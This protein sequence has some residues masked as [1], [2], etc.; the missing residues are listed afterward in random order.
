MSRRIAL[1]LLGALVLTLALEPVR[2]L[3][4]QDD[5]VYASNA[6]QMAQGDWSP[7]SLNIAGAWVQLVLGAQ[8][9]RLLPTVEPLIALTSLT[10][11][12]FLVMLGIWFLRFRGLGIWVAAFFVFPS[13]LQYGASFLTEIYAALLLTVFCVLME[14]ARVVRASIWGAFALFQ[15]QSAI[16]F[17]LLSLGGRLI[18]TRFDA[19]QSAWRARGALG[20]ALLILGLS[21][22][23]Y[24]FVLPK[25]P[26]QK[27]Y[28]AFV[29]TNLLSHP[30]GAWIWLSALLQNLLAVGW[31][32]FPLGILHQVWRRGFLGLPGLIVVASVGLCVA[33]VL[34]ALPG[35][36][37]NAGVLF[38]SYLPRFGSI[39]FLCFGV[40]GLWGLGFELSAM[41]G[42]RSSAKAGQ[43]SPHTDQTLFYAAVL[44]VIATVL[45]NSV[46]SVN[47]IRYVMT[48]CV[49]LYWWVLKRVEG[50]PRV[51]DGFEGRMT[52]IWAWSWVGVMGALSLFTNRYVLDVT[53]L[54]WKEAALLERSGVAPEM[55]SAGYGRDA[56]RLSLRCARYFDTRGEYGIEF[57]QNLSRIYED[58]WTPRYVI[59]PSNFAGVSLEQALEAH[60]AKPG[61]N[62]AQ[63]LTRSARTFGLP[64]SIAVRDVSLSGIVPAVP[65][66]LEF[67]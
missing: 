39:F 41:R 17:P 60:H 16:A 61:Q 66:C 40:V 50:E 52:R 19:R 56:Y 67:Q 7:S 59:K 54:R 33:G 64:H 29:L 23:I 26:L 65:K 43:I 4:V 42:S 9:L 14:Q 37:L 51:E 35:S 18:E 38:T 53:E 22:G 30:Q 2:A 57:F 5:G 6:V 45:F 47:D 27:G 63:A 31:F 46:R 3:V 13:W 8:L 10:W 36:V 34:L 20:A 1:W 21:L 58:G 24:F 15:L 28:L 49:P 62:Q 55:I 32:L 25:S 11:T 44:T 48:A 12:L